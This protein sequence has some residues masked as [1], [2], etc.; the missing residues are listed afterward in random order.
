MLQEEYDYANEMQAEILSRLARLNI[1]HGNVHGAQML[2]ER[3]RYLTYATQSAL[4]KKDRGV[5]LDGDELEQNQ[6]I[7]LSIFLTVDI[8]HALHIQSRDK[9]LPYPLLT[10]LTLS[11]KTCTLESR[12]QALTRFNLA[13]N[14]VWTV[15]LCFL[16]SFFLYPMLS[17][18]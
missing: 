16:P 2:S 15:A 7:M 14:Y 6:G 4:R 10:E 12:F 9:N 3:C 11:L 18:F 5:G 13:R 8:P 1:L 17:S